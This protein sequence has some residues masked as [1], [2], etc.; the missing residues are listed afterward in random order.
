[1]QTAFLDYATHNPIQPTTE[2]ETAAFSDYERAVAGLRREF[3]QQSVYFRECPNPESDTR[4]EVAQMVRRRF[5]RVTDSDILAEAARQTHAD[6]F[7]EWV[8]AYTLDWLNHVAV[9]R[10]TATQA[11]PNDCPDLVEQA[12]QLRLMLEDAG[13]QVLWSYFARLEDCEQGIDIGNKVV[14]FVRVEELLRGVI[15]GLDCIEAPQK[16]ALAKLVTLWLFVRTDDVPGR[17]DAMHP[18]D[19]EGAQV[20]AFADWL[21]TVV[22]MKS[23]AFLTKETR[24]AIAR[25]HCWFVQAELPV[26]F[27]LQ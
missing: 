6:V 27:P 8:Q 9:D 13:G 18:G 19:I 17:D 11:W 5:E 26:S 2:T 20:T 10:K 14:I 4:D 1:M 22:V 15:E 7:N 21:R 12:R 3:T 16:E 24:T 25:L 23:C